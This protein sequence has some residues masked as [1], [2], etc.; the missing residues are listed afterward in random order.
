VT[1]TSGF[2][3]YSAAPVEI[4]V[5]IEEAHKNKAFGLGQFKTWRALDIAGRFIA[6]EVQQQIDAGDVFVGDISVLNFNVVYEIGYAIGRKKR[7]IITRNSFVAGKSTEIQDVGIFDTIGYKDYSTAAEFAEILRGIPDTTPLELGSVVDHKQPAYLILPKVKTDWTRRLLSRLK[8]ARIS[9]RSFDPS[10]QSRLSALDAI[11]EVSRSVGVLV[12]LEPSSASDHRVHNLRAAFIGGLA[13]GMS[14]ALS[15]LQ[16]TNDPV[17]LDYRDL[18]RTCIHPKQIDEAVEEFALQVVEGMQTREP[19]PVTR[20]PANLLSRLDLGA[21]T[22]ENEV[23]DLEAYYFETDAYKRVRRGEVRIVVGRKGAGKTAIFYRVRDEIAKQGRPSIVLDL[24]P[25]GYQLVKFKESVLKLLELGTLEH[26]ITAFWEYLLL[27]EVCNKL[28][29][30]DKHIYLRDHRLTEPYQRLLEKY[31]S[32]RYVAEGDFSERMAALLSDIAQDYQTNHG[33]KTH[34]STPEITKLIYRHN[35]E[36]LRE[37]VESYL[38]RKESLWILFDNIDKGWPTHGLK[39]EDIVVIRTLIEA[40]RKVERA[41]HR[42]GLECHTVIF[43]RNDVYELLV[44][45]TSDRGKENR[46]LLDWTDKESLREVLRRRIIFGAAVSDESFERLWST[47]CTSHVHGEESAHYILERSLMRP[48]NLIDLVKHC[49]AFAVNRRHHKIE[50]MD[51]DKGVEAFSADLVTD[52]G[53]EIRDVLPAAADVLFAFASSDQLLRDSEVKA[54]L[55]KHGIVEAELP[56]VIEILLWYGFLGVVKEHSAVIYIFD[57]NYNMKLLKSFIPEP[58][59]A[60]FHV[61]EAF[62]KG[63]RL[64]AVT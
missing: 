5:A 16:Q 43:M 11:A 61:N 33:G 51:I 17:P 47:I 46:V 7:V 55:L 62:T 18:A 29:M 24:K 42:H 28:L 1:S 8:K 19:I 60:V 54:L 41:L 52:I 45:E 34:L 63:L 44:D 25:D 13:A 23:K 56:R 40:S 38:K 32:D 21:S 15:I 12:P 6:D 64:R 27:L 3:G 14:R 10:E 30:L 59:S 22:A 4:G 31:Q 50:E 2:I 39:G 48:R 58:G 57:C 37:E 36:S 35:V 49:R 53:Y 20:L 26:L 9:Y